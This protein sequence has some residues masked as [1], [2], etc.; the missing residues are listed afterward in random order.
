MREMHIVNPDDFN[1]WLYCKKGVEEIKHIYHSDDYSAAMMY[2]E[3]YGRYPTKSEFDQILKNDPNASIPSYGGKYFA[4]IIFKDYYALYEQEFYSANYER[5]YDNTALVSQKD[6]VNISKRV[7]K[8]DN[9]FGSSATSYLYTVI[10]ST[11]PELTEGWLNDQFGH[12]TDDYYEVIITPSETF[13]LTVGDRAEDITGFVIAMIVIIAIMAVCMFF[14]MRSSMMNR[15]KEIGIYRAIGV[16]KRNLIFRFGIESLVL[17]ALTVVV[18]YLLTSVYIWLC[19]GSSAVVKTIFFYPPW[20]SL[21]VLAL[22]LV[23]SILSGI[24][25]IISLLRKTPSEI[26]AKYDI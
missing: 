24:M 14:I 1:L 23:L 12:I 5:I 4:D 25:P 17:T 3:K 2:K 16:S 18:G 10:H 11:N 13:A 9:I 19:V 26:L 15:I 6:Y 7:G 8:T 20:Y 21:I 22:L